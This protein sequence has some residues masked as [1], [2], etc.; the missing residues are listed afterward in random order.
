LNK[1]SISSNVYIDYS[2]HLSYTST[3]RR[4]K[5]KRKL[6]WWWLLV[7]VYA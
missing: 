2:S 5:E 4:E 6:F 7:T 3:E 1:E